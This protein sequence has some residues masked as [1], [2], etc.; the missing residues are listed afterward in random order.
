M[1]N[2]ALVG[3]EV[4]YVLWVLLGENCHHCIQTLDPDQD[5]SY[6]LLAF[7]KNGC[8]AFVSGVLKQPGLQILDLG[9]VLI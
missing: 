3:E 6:G 7:L 4:L 1:H 2:V 9:F 5:I 8:N